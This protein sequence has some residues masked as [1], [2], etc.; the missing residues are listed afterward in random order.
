LFKTEAEVFIHKKNFEE[1]FDCK[2]GNHPEILKKYLQKGI[3]L[4]TITILD[5]ILEY[6]KNFD[7]KLT[8]PIWNFVSL[9]IRKY[10]PF[11]NIDVEKYKNV[12]K[13]IVL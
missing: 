1:L 7:K 3:T 8:D 13:E 11:L 12:L 2:T 9:R 5:M 10:R 6:V 4:E